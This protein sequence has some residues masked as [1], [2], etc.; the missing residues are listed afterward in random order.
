MNQAAVKSGLPLGASREII[1]PPNPNPA[2]YTAAPQ[3]FTDELPRA[4]L[5]VKLEEGKRDSAGST[6]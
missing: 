1:F 4:L 6:G 3:P 2:I 5:Y